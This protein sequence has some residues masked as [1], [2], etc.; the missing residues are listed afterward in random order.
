MHAPRGFLL[1]TSAGWAAY[2]LKITLD[3]AQ[4]V[5]LI[6]ILNLSRMCGL[7]EVCLAVLRML[8]TVNHGCLCCSKRQGITCP[9]T[10]PL[11]G[12]VFISHRKPFRL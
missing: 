8:V 10:L 9:D 3:Q 1:D 4:V 7:V 6:A 2:K 5:I 12:P 11:L